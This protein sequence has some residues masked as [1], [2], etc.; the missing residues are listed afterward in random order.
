[1]FSFLE[2]F[3]VEDEMTRAENKQT[4]RKFTHAKK[5]TVQNAINRAALR[6]LSLYCKSAFISPRKFCIVCL[7]H[8]LNTSFVKDGDSFSMKSHC[9][10]GVTDNKKL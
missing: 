4:A 3:E 7:S 5:K 1:M 8:K 6:T 2:E 9:S 10:T